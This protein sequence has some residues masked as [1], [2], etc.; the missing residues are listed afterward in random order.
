[1]DTA[2]IDKLLEEYLGLLDE[3]TTLRAALSTH[4][5][6]MYQNLAR[7]NF[8]AERGARYGQDFYDDRMQ[9]SRTVTVSG[10][11]SGG[12]DGVPVF[13]VTKAA[14]PAEVP[15][16]KEKDQDEGLGE[17]LNE[18]EDEDGEN[19]GDEE[20]EKAKTAPPKRTRRDPLHWYGLLAPM[21]LRRAQAQ[22]IE[23]VEKVVPKL[24]SVDVRMAEME[25]E[26]R[27]ARKKRAKA[28]TSAEK[29]AAGGVVK[30]A[31]ATAPVATEA[32]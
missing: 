15:A 11:G 21:P 4:Q 16:E 30:H 19:T 5:A 20:N 17:D 10:G 7:A 18:D 2:H 26:I 27:R 23:V 3:Y 24:V 8:T 1:M 13:V 28:E 6:D 12:K 9:A 14:D 25:I 31:E 29:E 22:A 32:S